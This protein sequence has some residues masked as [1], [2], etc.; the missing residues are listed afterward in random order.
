M[1][2]YKV[3]PWGYRYWIIKYK[4]KFFWHTIKEEVPYMGQ[5]ET[6]YMDSLFGTEQEAL[7][8][9]VKLRGK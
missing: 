6:Y 4:N 9:I 5:G 2:K 7:D 3:V 8:Y 1:R